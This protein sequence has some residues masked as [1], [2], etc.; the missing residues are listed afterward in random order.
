MELTP[1]TQPPCD[2][3][4]QLPFESIS[5]IPHLED[6]DVDHALDYPSNPATVRIDIVSEAMQS[7]VVTAVAKDAKNLA[8]TQPSQTSKYEAKLPPTSMLAVTTSETTEIYEGEV[9]TPTQPPTSISME[10]KG[11]YVHELQTASSVI[12]FSVTKPK[13]K[14]T[15]RTFLDE[16]PEMPVVTT[17]KLVTNSDSVHDVNSSDSTPPNMAE[18]RWNASSSVLTEIVPEPEP[19]FKSEFTTRVVTVSTETMSKTHTKAT[20]HKSSF[21]ITKLEALTKPEAK[22]ELTSPGVTLPSVKESDAA[23]K[24]TANEKTFIFVTELDGEF[25]HKPEPKPKPESTPSVATMSNTAKPEKDPKPEQNKSSLITS[26]LKAEIETASK[27]ASKSE[28]T[29]LSL[30]SSTVTTLSITKPQT[31]QNFEL[32]SSSAL[33]MKVE[34]PKPDPK[35][36]VEMTSSSMTLSSM[37]KPGLSRKSELNFGPT[38]HNLT[39]LEHKSD[40]ELEPEPTPQTLSLKITPTHTQYQTNEEI[41]AG[42]RNGKNTLTT[43]RPQREPFSLTPEPEPTF[44]THN[45]HD[46]GTI[47]GQPLSP[48]TTT[49]KSA[50]V[51]EVTTGGNSSINYH[52]RL[53]EQDLEPTV[54]TGTNPPPSLTQS[55]PRV[56]GDF[57]ATHIADMEGADI[58]NLYP[59]VSGTPAGAFSRHTTIAMT[60]PDEVT[61]YQSTMRKLESQSSA[62]PDL[63][64]SI[65][66]SNAQT[67][68]Y[69]VNLTDSILMNDPQAT[70]MASEAEPEPELTQDKPSVIDNL[71]DTSSK[72]QLTVSEVLQ[73]TLNSLSNVALSDY[74]KQRTQQ[75]TVTIQS[76]SIP[77]T[78]EVID[79]VLPRAEP[80]P[81]HEPRGK[82]T[83]SGHPLTAGVEGYTLESVVLGTVAGHKPQRFEGQLT[84]LAIDSRGA[85]FSS[86][87]EDRSSTLYKKYSDAVCSAVVEILS[88]VYVDNPSNCRVT[89]FRSGSVVA[90]FE[91]RIEGVLSVDADEIR[92]YLA[93]AFTVGDRAVAGLQ[94]DGTSVTIRKLKD[95]IIQDIHGT[96][97][98]TKT[99]LGVL[100]GV[101]TSGAA[102]TTQNSPRSNAVPTLSRTRTPVPVSTI[103]ESSVHQTPRQT[104]TRPNYTVAQHFSGRFRILTIDGEEVEYT[105]DLEKPNTEKFKS[106][107][108][109]V[110]S[111]VLKALYDTYPDD[112]GDCFVVSFQRGSIIANYTVTFKG[113]SVI[114]AADIRS[115]LVEAFTNSENSVLLRLGVDTHSFQ[116]TRTGTDKQ[117]PKDAGAVSSNGTEDRGYLG[118]GAVAAIVLCCSLAAIVVVAGVIYVE[119]RD[120]RRYKGLKVATGRRDVYIDDA[121]AGS[122]V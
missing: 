30:N 52:A 14:T 13:P 81:S 66:E 107:A 34:E 91:I 5:N 3:T 83:M 7:A 114:T 57:Q 72:P 55:T 69:T 15:S 79:S 120:Y 113:D 2:T 76:L 110:C 90:M 11:A 1:T 96:Q 102:L 17:P 115:K 105:S 64:V 56:Q 101:I 82:P 109:M 121:P 85:T 94:V 92:S 99:V 43:E 89:G 122:I 49:R 45:Q 67:Q 27:P 24:P 38:S 12:T 4:T 116:V 40:L 23:P 119:L 44:K 88:Q 98:P 41:A 48:A 35:L 58:G 21:A 112:L 53:L 46:P 117:P 6:I 16:Q 68:S 86:L 104:E 71:L 36:E 97:S 51:S 111:G 39:N 106:Y 31:N 65:P 9:W 61:L 74:V 93:A 95:S 29:L 77:T 22:P 70:S 25:K 20:T 100:E 60:S 84:I 78:G 18:P 103:T 50:M 75:T 8:E 62:S 54:D 42:P 37:V 32:N 73:T 80:E 10:D 19:E 59:V 63:T 118:G 26:E 108:G 87:L 33:I 47:N 28:F